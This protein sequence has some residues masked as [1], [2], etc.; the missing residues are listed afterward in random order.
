M[1]PN[2]FSPDAPGELVP[3]T[4]IDGADHA[5]VPSPLPP[6]W[7]WSEQLWPLLV[8]AHKAL[9]SLNGVGKHLLNPQLLLHPLQQREAQESSSLEGTYTDPEQ[10]MLFQLDPKFPASAT[11]Q[12]NA[13]REVF[14]YKRALQ[15]RYSSEQDLPLSLRLIRRLHEVLLEGVRGADRAP[16][17]FRRLQNQIGRPARFVPPPPDRLDDCLDAYEKYI[18]A[19]HA[20]D[21][22]VEAFLLHYQFEAIHPFRDGNGRVGRLLLAIMIAEWCDLSHQWLYMSAYFNR[23]RDEYIDRLYRI[24]T[25]G[26]WSEWMEFCLR[27][28]REQATDTERRCEDLIALNREF[29]DTV[30]EEIGGSH[31]LGM[32]VDELLV[33]PFVQIPQLAEKFDVAYNTAK[34]DVERLVDAEIL[35]EIEDARQR[36]FVAPRVVTVT[37]GSTRREGHQGDTA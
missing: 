11:D 18:H 28:V 16:G 12:V 35:S 2:D 6:D 36:T 21:P 15:L 19:E 7:T 4:T 37:F 23:H 31:R 24:S 30:Q 26:E 3:I 9:S 27:G 8:D 34:A 20:H 33:N 13:F 25:A 22:L 5:F 29:H 17:R 32:I 10:Q 14:N 1:D